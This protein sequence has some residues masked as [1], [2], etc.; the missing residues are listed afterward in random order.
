MVSLFVIVYVKIVGLRQHKKLRRVSEILA[1][2]LLPFK[3]WR[4]KIFYACLWSMGSHIPNASAT[5][6][7]V[8]L[9]NAEWAVRIV[10][11]Q[12]NPTMHDAFTLT[13]CHEMIH[14]ER[15]FYFFDFFTNDGKFVNWVNEVHADFGGI[16]KGLDGKRNRASEAMKYKKSCRKKL[17]RDSRSHPSWEKRIEYIE[18]YNF[19]KEL[20]DRIALDCNCKN[21]RLI[22]NVINFFEIID[23][24]VS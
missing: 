4:G 20:I 16:R 2:E 12:G 9:I 22:T 11:D 8:I 1:K 5:I 10:F 23:L 3:N 14:Q 13:I 19:N 21:T 17:D 24:E 18:N 15:D 7:G 6:P